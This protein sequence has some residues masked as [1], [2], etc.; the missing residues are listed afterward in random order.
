MD[1]RQFSTF[2]LTSAAMWAAT[3]MHS[4]YALSLDDLT[5]AD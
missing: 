5:K 4:V 2:T 3:S 1:R